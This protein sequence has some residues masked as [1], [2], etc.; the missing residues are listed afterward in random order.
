VTAGGDAPRSRVRDLADVRRLVRYGVAGGLSAL[1]HLGV[2][3]VLVEWAGVTPVPASTVG[4]LASVVVSYTL[5][6]S[7]VFANPGRH[8][9]QLPRFLVVTG[10]AL[11][12]NTSVLWVG[13]TLLTTHYVLVQLVALALIPLSN[14]LLNSLW[15]FR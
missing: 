5:Q 6:R 3:T 15:T 4:F 9:S 1:T 7:W 10:V 14:Y 13:T 8:R 12:L 11:G 2:L